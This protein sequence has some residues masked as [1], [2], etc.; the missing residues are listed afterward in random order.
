MPRFTDPKG[1]HPPYSKL[2]FQVAPGQTNVLFGGSIEVRVTVEGGQPVAGKLWLVARSGTNELRTMMFLASD[3]S[4][5][6]SLAN[7]REPSEY[8]VTDGKARSH[9]YRTDIRYTPQIT[10]VEVTSTFPAY[11]GMPARTGK[12]AEDPQSLPLDTRLDF[13]VFSNRPLKEGEMTITPVLGGKEQKL[14]LNAPAGGNCATGSFTLVEPLVFSIKVTDQLGLDSIDPRQGRFNISPDER[15]RLFVLEPGRDAVATPEFRVPV[16]VEATDDYGISR[17]VWLRGHNRSKERPF[18]MKLEPKSSAKQV[19][20]VGDF[21][22]GKLGTRPGDIIEYYFEASDNDPRGPNIALSRLYRLEVIS[23]EQYELILKQAAA[24][25]ALFEPYLQLS[26]WLRR[27]SVRAGDLDKKMEK[28]PS[29]EKEAASKELDALARDLEKYEQEIGKLLGQ[30]LFFDVEQ[31]FRETLVAQHTRIQALRKSLTEGQGAA[32]SEVS[33]ELAEMAGVQEADVANPARQIAGVAQ[34]LA[35]ANTFVKLAQ[36]QALLARMAERF[37]DRHEGFNRSDQMAMQE[38]GFQQ[39]GVRD[40]LKTLLES[41]PVLLEQLPDTADYNKLREQVR[42]FVDAVEKAGI[43]FDMQN[44]FSMFAKPDGM[45]AYAAAQAAAQKM[46]ALIARCNQMGEQGGMCLKFQPTI[47]TA[48]GSTL[49]QILAAL[50]AGQQSGQGGEDG[51]GLYNDDVALYGPSAELAGQQNPGSG[52]GRAMTERHTESI[53][54]GARDQALREAPSPGRVRLRTDARFPLRY[55]DVVGEY[56]K[57]I[58]ESEST[59]DG[60]SK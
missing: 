6:Q 39:G 53:P 31:A 13:R 43:E 14:K 57:I 28:G 22:L 42:A 38:L 58:G 46:D 40:G 56:F 3:R 15:P 18:Q 37:N 4:F 47:Q 60:G 33:R 16:R 8:Y 27:M 34:L 23:K 5:F 2:R 51:Y 10:M 19:Q 17:V 29:A 20:G 55:R 52:D 12:L 36:Q 32:L 21:D 54:G 11:T 30:S 59:R 48:M 9:R 1:D 44:S 7:L 25:K 26:S 45:D 49:Q 41:L 35:R 50:G 24:R